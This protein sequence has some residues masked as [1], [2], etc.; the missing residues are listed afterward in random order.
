MAA[1]AG[2]RPDTTGGGDSR[3]HGW[4][5]VGGASGASKVPTTS[6]PLAPHGYP[7]LEPGVDRSLRRGAT[8]GQ[9][10]ETTDND[11]S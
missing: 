1:P 7:A 11:R 9:R 5:W 3:R 6:T 2:E 8:V 4:D 10:P